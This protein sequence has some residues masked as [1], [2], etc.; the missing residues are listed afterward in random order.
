MSHLLQLAAP[1]V[2]PPTPSRKSSHFASLLN[3]VS[4]P[5]HCQPAHAPALLFLGGAWEAESNGRERLQCGAV[6]PPSNSTGPPGFLCIL[7]MQDW[8]FRIVVIATLAFFK[9]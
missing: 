4:Q 2:I 3:S 7:V 6:R 5:S 9:E 8:E 1:L